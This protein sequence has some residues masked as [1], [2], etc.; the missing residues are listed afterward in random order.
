MNMKCKSLRMKKKKR[1]VN[2][3]KMLYN[4]DVDNL[5]ILV[6]LNHNHE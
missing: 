4:L 2:P 3:T 1:D 5:F 6:F